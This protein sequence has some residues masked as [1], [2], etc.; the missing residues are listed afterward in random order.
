MGHSLETVSF[1]GDDVPCLVE[2]SL[3][4]RM[5]LSG[6]IE[7]SLRTDE[8]EA[9]VETRCHRCG[10]IRTVSVTGEQALRLY[11]DRIHAART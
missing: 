4:C 3:A 10:D 5:C 8:W 6:D 11:V 9:E 1:R 2:A 7:W